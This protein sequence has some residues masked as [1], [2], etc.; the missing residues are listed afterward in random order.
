MIPLP[1][2]VHRSHD[3]IFDLLQSTPRSIAELLSKPLSV[4]DVSSRDGMKVF[5][6]SL[7][8]KR[9]F[10]SSL[11]TK[12]NRKSDFSLFFSLSKAKLTCT[13]DYAYGARG[14]PPVIPANSTLI[15]E[16]SHNLQQ[17]KNLFLLL[18]R[19]FRNSFSRVCSRC[20]C[21]R[22]SFSRSTK[23]ATCS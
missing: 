12:K 11:K 5:P 2:F 13:P 22:L 15:F 14:F 23:T 3:L 20:C 1:L 21:H 6:N 7:S 19:F 17:K 18:F 10:N 8:V 16:V 4:S 9:Y